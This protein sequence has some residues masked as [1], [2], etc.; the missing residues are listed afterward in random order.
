VRT[1]PFRVGV[2]FAVFCFG[3]IPAR[4]VFAHLQLSRY[5]TLCQ[6]LDTLQ[7]SHSPFLILRFAI[8]FYPMCWFSLSVSRSSNGVHY[9]FIHMLANATKFISAAVSP[10]R[11]FPVLGQP[12][13][14]LGYSISVLG[15]PE[16]VLGYSISVL[17]QPEPVLGHSVLVLG[18]PEQKLI[19]DW[20]SCSGRKHRAFD[21]S[22]PL[23]I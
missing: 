19:G 14:V 16:P 12:E 2:F 8:S 6:H 10:F 21:Q 5:G 18:Q 1:L 17:G 23:S 9:C 4:T 13:P 3:F 11:L 20:L 7:I 15:Q 22:G